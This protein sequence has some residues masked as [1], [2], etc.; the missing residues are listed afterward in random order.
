MGTRDRANAR[1]DLRSRIF[2]SPAKMFAMLTA[3]VIASSA[4]TARSKNS[5]TETS[6]LISQEPRPFDFP[7]R[8]QDI[9][10]PYFVTASAN[11]SAFSVVGAGVTVT[12]IPFRMALPEGASRVSAS[13]RRFMFTPGV[14]LATLSRVPGWL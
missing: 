14:A 7:Y 9:S 3:T 2:Y 5:Q 8:H 13:T 10:R 11:W 1:A 12:A 4:L 6:L